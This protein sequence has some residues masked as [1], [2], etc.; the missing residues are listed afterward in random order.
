MEQTNSPLTPVYETALGSMYSGLCEE[1]LTQ[2]PL[3]K[4][5]GRVQLILTSPPFPLNRKKSYGNK[6]G[7]EYLEWLKELAPILTEFLTPNGSIAIELGNAWE[8]GKPVMSTLPIRALLAFM[9]AAKLNLCQEFICYNPAR[10]PSP[11]EWV[12]VKRIRV[13]DAFTRVW[14]MSPTP[15]PKANNKN[16]LTKY[17]ESMEELLRRGTYNDGHRPSEHHIGKTSFLKNNGGAIPPNVF[18]PAESE[19]QVTELLPLSNTATNDPYV[20]YCKEKGLDIHPARMQTPLAEFFINFLTD[21]TDL[22]MDP[23]A[24]SNTTGSVSERLKR[25]WISIEVDP[26]YAT[27]SK[28]RFTEGLLNNLNATQPNV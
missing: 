11:A 20:K 8:P 23:F 28:S 12:T 26:N 24:G 14:W 4:Q 19:P 2:E 7:D 27:A 25:K 15:Y 17:S 22:V 6:Q 16:I 13:K 10:L 1:I 21:Q 18:I 9:D 5:K 3:I